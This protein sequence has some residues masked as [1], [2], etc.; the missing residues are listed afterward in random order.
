MKPGNND[1]E[2]LATL[3]PMGQGDYLQGG[4]Y[5]LLCGYSL[6]RHDGEELWSREFGGQRRCL[7]R[8]RTAILTI[9]TALLIGCSDSDDTE[10]I[11][12]TATPTPAETQA[13]TSSPTHEPE[14]TIEPTSAP[15]ET[16]TS[17]ANPVVV[18]STN[19]GDIT[20]ELFQDKVPNTVDNFLKL[21]NDGFYDGIIFHRISDDF[22]IQAGI[23]TTDG[24]NKFSPYGPI[25][26]ETHPEATHVD[27]AIS[28]ARTRDLNSATSQFFI[29]D[30]PRHGLDNAYAV[31][32]VVTEGIEVVREI[33]A[34][35]N[36]GRFEPS[37]GGGRPLE[38]IV[39]NS[40]TV[41]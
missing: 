28:M 16:G 41:Q 17:S 8:R 19:F 21:V 15:T 32:G 13:P 4:R 11:V 14:P 26:L 37:P 22:M 33:A 29:C 9:A 36:D 25:A 3:R 2:E 18:M 39:I 40:I 30:G 27:G 31:F 7:H 5:E 34:S 20:I 35:P 24:T 1:P 38:Q 12:A 10:E 23:E 6:Y